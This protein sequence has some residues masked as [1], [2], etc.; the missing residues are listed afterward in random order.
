MATDLISY[1]DMLALLGVTHSTLQRYI[2]D[3][4][5]PQPFKLSPST[6]RVYWKRSELLNTSVAPFIES[7]ELVPA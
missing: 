3:G 5:V 2:R 6:K 1:R 7:G 4:V